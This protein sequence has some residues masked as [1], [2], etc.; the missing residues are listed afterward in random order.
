M[1]GTDGMHS[2]MLRSAKAS[3]LVGQTTEGISFPGIYDR[4]RNVH[5]Y[6]QDHG[7]KGDGENNLV[8]LDYNPPTELTQDNF[9]GHFVYGM[10]SA[11]VETVISSGRVIVENR[12]LVSADEQQIMAFARQMGTKLW[13]KLA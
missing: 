4:F 11:H 8:I 6:I 7:F 5:R 13:A 10:D 9:L 12:C 2:D 3:F 1:L